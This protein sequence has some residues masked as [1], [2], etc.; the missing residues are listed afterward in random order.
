MFHFHAHKVIEKL[1]QNCNYVHS[2]DDN[3]KV[4]EA[5]FKQLLIALVELLPEF[6]QSVWYSFWCASLELINDP[7]SVCLRSHLEQKCYSN[8]EVAEYSKCYDSGDLC[9][10]YVH[11]RRVKDFKESTFMYNFIKIA[12]TLPIGITICK[13]IR[14]KYYNFIEFPIIYI[15]EMLSLMTGDKRKDILGINFA[16]YG[17]ED[18]IDKL[19]KNIKDLYDH[20]QAAKPYMTTLDGISKTDHFPYQHLVGVRPILDASK[21]YSFLIVLHIDVAK[22]SEISY[23]SKLMYNLLLKLPIKLNALELK[24][25]PQLARRI[26]RTSRVM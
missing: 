17:Q 22:S 9:L 15:N 24:P 13:V 12:E 26:K 11:P 4:T 14:R 19:E 10:D 16:D 25:S 6:L 2:T 1:L 8:E 5:D 20:L 18:E 7:L 23:Y 21:A 3:C